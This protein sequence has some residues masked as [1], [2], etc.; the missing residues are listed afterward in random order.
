MWRGYAATYTNQWTVADRQGYKAFW[1][2][3][4]HPVALYRLMQPP[5]TFL[6]GVRPLGL[7]IHIGVHRLGP[8]STES[9]MENPASYRSILSDVRVIMAIMRVLVVDLP[10]QVVTGWVPALECL[11]LGACGHLPLHLVLCGIKWPRYPRT[12]VLMPLARYLG[13]PQ[14]WL[15]GDPAHAEPGCED[16]LH[17]I[18]M[19]G[20]PARLRPLRWDKRDWCISHLGW[21][22]FSLVQPPLQLEVVGPYLV[23]GAWF[24]SYLPLEGTGPY[25]DLVS[26][27]WRPAV[28]RAQDPDKVRAWFKS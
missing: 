21:V 12:P 1:Q 13:Y 20:N 7:V 14:S 11:L 19:W 8:R 26:H 9:C 18:D 4:S 2:V 15:T 3:L 24:P 25:L 27:N 6:R 28:P 16:K 23:W 10:C 17:R 5:T 22:L